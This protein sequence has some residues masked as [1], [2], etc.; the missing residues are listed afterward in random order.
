MSPTASLSDS[1]KMLFGQKA[2]NWD[3]LG[4][5]ELLPC[6]TGRALQLRWCAGAA[7]PP[8]GIT[9]ADVPAAAEHTCTKLPWLEP[10][11]C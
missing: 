8:C 10:V 2:T 9:V 1:G 11:F 4:A 3:T 7:G 6:A 5:G